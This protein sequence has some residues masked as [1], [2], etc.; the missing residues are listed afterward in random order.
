MV[1]QAQLLLSSVPE[2]TDLEMELDHGLGSRTGTRLSL[3]RV[4]SQMSRATMVRTP[5][6]RPTTQDD[7]VFA[8]MHDEEHIL[9]TELKQSEYRLEESEEAESPR[10]PDILIL[11]DKAVVTVRT[12]EDEYDTDLETEGTART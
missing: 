6:D 1:L 8:E 10:E 5:A 11:E 4:P 3:Q 12:D 2:E 7:K 9:I